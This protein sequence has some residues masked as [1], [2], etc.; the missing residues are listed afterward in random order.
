LGARLIHFVLAV[1]PVGSCASLGAELAAAVADTTNLGGDQIAAMSPSGAWALRAVAVPDAVLATRWHADGEGLVVCNGTVTGD[2]ALVA[3]DAVLARYRAGGVEAA[4]GPLSGTYN[5]T[6]LAP[7]RGLSISGDLA[8][9]YPLYHGAA[10]D[11]VVVSNRSA[12]VAAALGTSGWD[13]GPLAWIISTGHI[14]GEQVPARGVRSLRAGHVGQM[15]WGASALELGPPRRRLMPGPGPGEG[16][17]DLSPV[18]WDAVTD[19]LIGQVRGLAALDTPL[20]L[21]LSGGK[22]SRLLLAL[23]MGAG[24]TD[25]ETYTTG[26]PDSGDL[27][28]AVRLAAAAGVAH[29]TGVPPQARQPVSRQ[30]V[31]AAVDD[32]P[33]ADVWSEVARGL[34]RYDGI[35]ATWAAARTPDKP[36]SLMVKG[37][38]G[39]VYRY[40]SRPAPL[41]SLGLLLPSRPGVPLDVDVLTRCLMM[42]I[43]PLHL[44]TPSELARQRAWMRGWVNQTVETIRPDL[45]PDLFY[46]DHRLGQL[47][48]PI[49][50]GLPLRIVANPLASA[51]ATSLYAELSLHARSTD[52]L[53]FEI[54]RRLAP[55]LL[56]VPLVDQVWKPEIHA[57]SGVPLPTEPFGGARPVPE[58]RPA[59]WWKRRPHLPVGH[60]EPVERAR[61]RKHELERDLQRRTRVDWLAASRWSQPRRPPHDATRIL[62]ER[63]PDKVAALFREAAGAGLGEICHVERLCRLTR[64]IGA[65][66]QPE[67]LQLTSALGVAM[68]LTGRTQR[69]VE[70]PAEPKPGRAAR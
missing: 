9:F 11:R 13:L 60:S 62:F 46:I 38:A 24:L 15:A 69:M 49:T 28:C 55:G 40:K 12:T 45:L 52:R 43:D 23:M 70:T 30:V 27:L 68:L 44:L 4:T 59:P 7:E 33:L 5:L 21:Q 56:S 34:G 3:L 42:L 41:A 64:R 17:P 20:Y 26:A 63:E 39:E 66:T 22:D 61:A 32:G 37:W 65:L 25:L 51:P 10:P 54:I 2:S 50:Q 1:G 16:R 35:V 58:V 18:E 6:C 19:E 29:R 48:G 8:G 57:L 36:T 14:C 53:H 31:G 67:E 47:A